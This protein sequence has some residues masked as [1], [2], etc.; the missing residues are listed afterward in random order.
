MLLIL[1]ISEVGLRITVTRTFE[2]SLATFNITRRPLPVLIKEYLEKHARTPP[3][4]LV[5]WA[6]LAELDRIE[7][8]FTTVYS[9]L[10][11][12]R[13]PSAPART[14][15]EAAAL[16]AGF[17]PDASKEIESLLSEYQLHLYSRKIG[18]LAR[19]QMA[20]IVIRKEARRVGIQQRLRAFRG[21]FRH[22]SGMDPHELA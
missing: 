18:S 1:L 20:A 9:S 2:N 12:L 7:R 14:P 8:T 13:Q 17:L 21:I 3:G 6:A 4:W 16:L 22:G 11:W 10:H 19:A 15:A 5:R